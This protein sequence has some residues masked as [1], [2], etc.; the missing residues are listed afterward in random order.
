MKWKQSLHN[1]TAFNFYVYC[2]RHASSWTIEV[3]SSVKGFLGSCVV[4]PC[5]FN[6]PDPARTPTKISGIWLDQRSHVIYHPDNSKILQQYK[7]RTELLGDATQK[8]CSWKIEPLQR[9]DGGP[10]HF[11]IEMEGFENYSFKANSVSISVIDKPSVALSMKKD[12]AVG[13]TTVASCSVSPFCPTSPPVFEWSH[14][15]EARLQSQQ[16]IDGQWKT[17]VTLN[18]LPSHTDHNKPLLCTVRFEGGVDVSRSQTFK[19]SGLNSVLT[20]LFPCRCPSG[21]EGSVQVRSEGGRSCAFE[22]LQ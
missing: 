14:S 19:R 5:T 16:F 20:V 15:G 17:T 12:M 13:Q 8:N 7:D 18:F 3:P 4:I 10:F 9:N 21:C 2:S 11:R 6:Y 1:E 22:M